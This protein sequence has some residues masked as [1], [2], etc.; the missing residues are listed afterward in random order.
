M[1][2]SGFSW[3]EYENLPLIALSNVILFTRDKAANKSL[4]SGAI[5]SIRVAFHYRFRFIN[6]IYIRREGGE[7]MSHAGTN[8][9]HQ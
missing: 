3:F 5:E 9:Y 2:D 6:N 4:Y 1:Y 8:E 7:R